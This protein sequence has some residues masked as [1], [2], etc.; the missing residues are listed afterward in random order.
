MRRFTRENV[1]PA[2]LPAK[3]AASVVAGFTGGAKACSPARSPVVRR[4]I[5]VVVFMV[6]EESP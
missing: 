4:K 3:T 1:Q 5:E 6:R 2:K